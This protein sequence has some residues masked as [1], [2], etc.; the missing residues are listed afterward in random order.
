MQ[1]KF[2]VTI[3]NPVLYKPPSATEDTLSKWENE[4]PTIDDSL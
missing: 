4:E 3:E 1:S 2:R